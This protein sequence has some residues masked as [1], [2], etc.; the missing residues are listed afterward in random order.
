MLLCQTLRENPLIYKGL[1]QKFDVTSRGLVMSTH[2]YDL[3]HSWLI[4]AIVHNL[5][6]LDLQNEKLR[7]GIRNIILG[8]DNAKLYTHN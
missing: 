5:G 7:L 6:Q 3:V 1:K 8:S 2:K 4:W